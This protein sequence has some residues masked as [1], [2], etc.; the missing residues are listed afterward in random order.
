MKKILF[1]GLLMIVA[2]SCVH[3][4]NKF[5]KKPSK[6]ECAITNKELIAWIYKNRMTDEKLNRFSNNRVSV[7]IFTDQKKAIHPHFLKGLL[8]SD[9]I[10]DLNVYSEFENKTI[11]YK[12]ITFL[13]DDTIMIFDNDN[14]GGKYYDRYLLQ[15]Y[16]KSKISFVKGSRSK[17][18]IYIVAKYCLYPDNGT[19]K[20][21]SK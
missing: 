8:K 11:G 13:L 2:S 4:K 12:G 17:G 9:T 20:L 15:N 16:P 5:S 18:G 10:I 3:F 7:V 6:Q 14:I 1:I 19:L 21:W